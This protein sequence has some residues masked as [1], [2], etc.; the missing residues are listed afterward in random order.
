MVDG[1]SHDDTA[2]RAAPLCERVLASEPGRARQLNAGAALA[3]GDV[4]WFL[5]ADTVASPAAVDALL[6]ALPLGRRCWGR[7]DVRLSG[8][9][10][11]LKVIAW[12]MNWRSRLTGIATGDQGLFV[13]RVCFEAA[14]RFPDQPLMEDVVLS[15]R[16]KRLSR[17]LCLT[18]ALSTSSRRWEE[19]GIARTV[20][21]MWAIRAAFFLGASPERLAGWYRRSG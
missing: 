19:H 2:Q 9:A 21:L 10:P 15:R 8:S 5:H 12:A 20:L 3:A 14:G 4:L 1:G 18:P 16:L 17:P 7:F 6:S 11:V 13:T